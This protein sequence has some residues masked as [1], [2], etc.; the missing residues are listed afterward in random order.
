MAPQAF[1]V[2]SQNAL[3]EKL[4]LSIYSGDTRPTWTVSPRDARRFQ[5][6]PDADDT[7]AIMQRR[8]LAGK[9]TSVDVAP[10]VTEHIVKVGD[11]YRL[12]SHTGKN[13]G[14]FDS[15]EAAAKHEAE[16]NYFK[17]H[18]SVVYEDAQD[19]EDDSADVPDDPCAYCGQN[20]NPRDIEF[21]PYC[22]LYCAQAAERDFADYYFGDR[23]DES[24]DDMDNPNPNGEVYGFYVVLANMGGKEY[25]EAPNLEIARSLFL[26]KYPGTPI[27]HIEPV[28][29]DAM[30][31]A[32]ATTSPDKKTGTSGNKRCEFCGSTK[33]VKM[34][35]D[36]PICKNCDVEESLQLKTFSGF[37][38]EQ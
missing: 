23:M 34:V 2:V 29:Y 6:R 37:L 27:D 10:D 5:T 25:I 8:G 38:R 3:G 1:V 17:T 12:L 21:Y 22:S 9:M 7:V 11:K 18:E 36:T 15:H 19:D 32:K 31:E 4:Y 24:V 13:L 33:D 28:D 20:I 35:D 14:T 30:M 16:V 26:S